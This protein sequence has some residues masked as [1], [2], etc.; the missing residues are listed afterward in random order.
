MRADSSAK[1]WLYWGLLGLSRLTSFTP[2]SPGLPEPLNSCATLGASGLAGTGPL[3]CCPCVASPATGSTAWS[4]SMPT[5]A[6]AATTRAAPGSHSLSWAACWWC[7][8]EPGS[9]A[10]F[11]SVLAASWGAPKGG[12]ADTGMKLLSADAAGSCGAS[13]MAAGST[14]SPAS[15]LSTGPAD[16]SDNTAASG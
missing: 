14:A 4:R 8:G 6:S 5:G 10:P 3:P 1:A 15:C 16:A 9:N 2:F 13:W 11:A 12:S 7:A